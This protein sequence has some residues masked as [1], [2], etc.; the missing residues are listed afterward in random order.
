M[1][2]LN[3]FPFNGHHTLTHPCLPV[4]LF[5][6]CL[7]HSNSILSIVA[8]IFQPPPHDPHMFFRNSG[9]ILA[10]NTRATASARSN[11]CVGFGQHTLLAPF[12]PNTQVAIHLFSN[13]AQ[14][15]E[16]SVIPLYTGSALSSSTDKKLM[17][18]RANCC[19][20]CLISSDFR[21]WMGA[22]DGFASWTSRSTC[23]FALV[24]SS[25]LIFVLSNSLVVVVVGVL[26]IEGVCVERGAEGRSGRR[27]KEPCT[28]NSRAS[29]N[30]NMIEVIHTLNLRSYRD[31]FAPHGAASS[32]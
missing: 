25:V 5:Y 26:P 32:L 18:C 24:V 7:D 6:C 1:I 29:C 3:L 8:F 14:S 31:I 17:I 21:W 4:C 2:L 20:A 23:K 27:A 12:Y 15:L 10:K 11:T 22:V 13:L 19:L 28:S 30:S 16:L 9:G